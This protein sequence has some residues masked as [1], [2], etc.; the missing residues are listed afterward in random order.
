MIPWA[1]HS[2]WP[3][4]ESDNGSS[5][6]CRVKPLRLNNGILYLVQT[7][8]GAGSAMIVLPG[9]ADGVVFELVVWGAQSVNTRLRDINPMSRNILFIQVR[10]H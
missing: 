1:A 3:I 5:R 9:A 7:N 8:S 4:S 2:S 10:L 6:D